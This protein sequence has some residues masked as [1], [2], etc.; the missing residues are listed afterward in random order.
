[1]KQS[2]LLLVA[3]VAGFGQEPQL[4]QDLNLLVGKQ[5][6]VQR[7]PL[8]Q[9]GTYTHVLTY[10]GKQAKV[11]SVKSVHV[12]AFPQSAMNRLPPET[13]AT[14]EDYRKSATIVVEFDDQTQLD[15]CTTIS[16]NR[17][18]DYFELVPGQNIESGSPPPTSTSI[19]GA[20]AASTPIPGG[21]PVAAIRPDLLSDEE[22]KL[23]LTGRGKEHAVEVVDMGLMAAQG[24][25]VPH[26]VLYMPEAVL[27][28][29][30]ESARQQFTQYQPSEE[31]K[32]RSLMIVA[33]GYVG[34]TLSEGCTS[35]T[36]IVLL[37]DPSGGIVREA[38]L[39]ESVGETWRNN[40]GATNECQALRAKFFL[41][42]VYKV[43]DAAP[44]GEFLVAVFSGSVKTKVYKIKKKHQSK[45]ALR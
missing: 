38:Y 32:R 34:N 43:R 19:V 22:V 44:N 45:L 17:L 29:R 27:A 23:A 37:S 26:L 6:T 10:A 28:M 41:D 42:D 25:E 20:I 31:D 21:N 36:R 15:S 13:R 30:S 4:I 40:L 18:R 24:K 8:C 11:I 39:T 35:I 5:V 1:M 9:L 33:H 12:A 14:I 3:A 2:I 7:V 16:P